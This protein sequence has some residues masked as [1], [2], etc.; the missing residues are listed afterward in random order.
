VIALD[1]DAA[2]VEAARANAAANGV[3]VDVRLGDALVAPLPAA[4]VAVANIARA[5]VEAVAVRFG[6][7][8]LIASGYLEGEQPDPDGWAQA[9]RRTAEGWAADLLAR[10]PS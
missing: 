2:A 8:L 5:P 6:G 1:D 4:E 3:Q 10:D 7:R 9:E